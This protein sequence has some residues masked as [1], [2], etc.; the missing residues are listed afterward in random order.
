MN[1]RIQ[2]IQE[3]TIPV[4][5]FGPGGD[6]INAWPEMPAVISVPTNPLGKVLDK[7]VAI[8]GMAGVYNVTLSTVSSSRNLTAREN[9]KEIQE[10]VSTQNYADSNTQAASARAIDKA[11]TNKGLFSNDIGTGP[12]AKTR[13]HNNLR[14]FRTASRKGLNRITNKQGTLFEAD[15]TWAKSA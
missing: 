3:L 9:Y 7:I 2:R 12:R 14:T 5:K 15:S 8:M 11:G 6:F 10:N 13:P 4:C 1:I